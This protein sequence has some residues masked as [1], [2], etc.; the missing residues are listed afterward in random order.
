MVIRSAVPRVDKYTELG[1]RRS[2]VELNHEYERLLERDISSFSFLYRGIVYVLMF[3]GKL[4]AYRTFQDLRRGWGTYRVYHLLVK[5]TTL[6]T[7]AV[8][9]SDNCLFRN[10][11]RNTVSVVRLAILVFAMSSYLITQSVLSPFLD[12][13]WNASEWVSGAFY[14][15]FAALGL[16]VTLNLSTGAEHALNGPMLYTYV[17]YVH[18]NIGLRFILFSTVFIAEVMDLRSVSKISILSMSFSHRMIDF[19]IIDISWARR[20]VKSECLL[21]HHSVNTHIFQNC[22]AGSISVSLS[23]SYHHKITD[24]CAGIDI[25]SPQFV[26]L[27]FHPFIPNKSSPILQS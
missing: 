12:P 13:V 14:V 2:R 5:L 10:A 6:L 25:F 20:F 23:P 1:M 16:A 7:V 19:L 3:M 26:L 8:L 21:P 22:R 9:N 18:E 24:S 15:A 11:N 4:I 27:F 17:S